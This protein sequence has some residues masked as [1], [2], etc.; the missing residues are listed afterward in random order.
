MKL[1]DESLKTVFRETD[2]PM[3]N[4]AVSVSS[5]QVKKLRC[6]VSVKAFLI[7]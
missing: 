4:L 2:S 5:R 1:L 6:V 3:H 7:Q